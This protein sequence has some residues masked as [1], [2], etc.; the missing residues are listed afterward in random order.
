MVFFSNSGFYFRRGIMKKKRIAVIITVLAFAFSLVPGAYAGAG[1]T[2]P[3]KPFINVVEAS[4]ETSA[5]TAEKQ[6]EVDESVKIKSS[7]AKQI[8]Q[9]FFKDTAGLELVSVNLYKKWGQS[10]D[11]AWNIYFRSSSPVQEGTADITI[12]A[13]TGA[14]L[15]FSI[16]VSNPAGQANYIAAYTRK[17]AAAIAEKFLKDRLKIDLSDYTLQADD[18][19]SYNYK[20]G[21]VKEPVY[22]YF[23]YTKSIDGIYLPNDTIYVNVNGSTGDVISFSRNE[24]VLNMD[25][26]PPAEGVL[27]KEQAF[28]KY[29]DLLGLRLQYTTIYSDDYFY[30]NPPKIMLAYVPT[31]YADNIDAYTGEY[32]SY[33][34]T[35]TMPATLTG[36]YDNPKPLDPNAKLPEGVKTDEEAEALAQK[37]KKLAEKLFGIKFDDS[38]LSSYVDHYTHNS[39]WNFNWNKNVSDSTN[40]SLYVSINRE[41]GNLNNLSLNKYNYVYYEKQEKVKEAISWSEGCA[42]AIE[43]I[44][45]ILPDYYGFF[46]DQ[47]VEPQ[48]DEET[49][50]IVKE[51]YYNFSRVVNGVVFGSN[52]IGVTIDRET[53]DVLNVYFNWNDYDFPKPDTVITEEAAADLYMSAMD[54]RLSYFQ[55]RT[56]DKETGTET[57]NPKPILVYNFVRKGFNYASSMFVDAKTG[58]LKD[59]NGKPLSLEP[60]VEDPTAPDSWAQRSINLLMAQ[61]IVKNPFVNP[62]S[63]LTKAEAVKL[64]S[65]AKGMTYYYYGQQLTSGTFEDVPVGDEYFIYVENA[66]KQGIIQAEEGS[67]FNG[68]ELISKEEFVRL[69]VNTIGYSDIAKHN[70][71]FKLDGISAADEDNIG[72]IAIA[73]A[74]GV[75]P[76]REGE[77][78]DGS[79]KITFAEAAHAVY[80][81]LKYI[82]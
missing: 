73:S 52:T 49:K 63:E 42:K 4:G 20:Y 67:K 80:K 59:W 79:S 7:E 23:T 29:K 14:I 40:Y 18:Y 15:N 68:G 22:Y 2:I 36:F 27:P 57:V 45:E 13:N 30:S 17:E 43:T 46:M 3:E 69:I 21:G 81:S 33:D 53:G 5:A 38:T 51:H 54:A 55:T 72:Y 65:L 39:T 75:L 8:A 78:Y 28:E 26:L 58:T 56:Y 64:L 9:E 50:N 77:S 10:G 31:F 34:G 1:G 62:N 6:Q 41:T 74:L 66:V 16:W 47:S 11:P 44:K 37:Y 61:G 60:V 82:K 25:E 76:V 48:Y 32:I 12:N 70:K 19:Y 71:I 35:K 24:T